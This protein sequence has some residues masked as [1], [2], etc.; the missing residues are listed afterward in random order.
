MLS[1][2]ISGANIWNS[3]KAILASLFLVLSIWQNK[4]M[5]DCYSICFWA[6]Q[7]S[8]ITRNGYKNRK[9]LLE[10]FISL[11]KMCSQ[12]KVN[13]LKLWESTQLRVDF[14]QQCST[15][16]ISLPKKQRD[17]KAKKQLR[18]KKFCQYW[19]RK[20]Q[21]MKARR[22]WQRRK[23]L[24][25]ELIAHLIR[26]GILRGMKKQEKKSLSK[27]SAYSKSLNNF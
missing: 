6:Y 9:S 11:S 15:D 27:Y 2:A 14:T 21:M 25:T 23:E 22:L 19:R 17:S 20:I 13:K 16:F 12:S 10:I 7:I 24:D 4:V 26:N 18:N 3:W 8:R 5:L 1:K